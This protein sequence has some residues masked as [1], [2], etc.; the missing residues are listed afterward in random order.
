MRCHPFHSLLILVLALGLAACDSATTTRADAELIVGTWQGQDVRART[1][2][3]ISV[4]V[5]D[6][7]MSGDVAQF[8]FGSDGT[9][10]FLLDLA[11]GRELSIPQT[12][13]S[14]PVDQTVSFSGTYTLNEAANT[15]FLSAGQFPSGLTLGYDFSGDNALTIIADDP[16]TLALLVGLATDDETIQLLASAVTGG[17]IAY[18]RSN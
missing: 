18:A 9:Y 3:G 8:T 6:L 11:Q 14:I 1:V 16:E 12:S 2:V 5:L 15:L 17:S 10:S 7:D 4:P 13:V